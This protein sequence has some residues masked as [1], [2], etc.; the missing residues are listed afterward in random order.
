[1]YPYPFCTIKHF[2]TL[3]QSLK[4]FD[5]INNTGLKVKCPPKLDQYL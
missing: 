5:G 4:K 3:L 1:M 2:V